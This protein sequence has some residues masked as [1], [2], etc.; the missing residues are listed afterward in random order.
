MAALDSGRANDNPGVRIW[1]RRIAW[2]E[3]FWIL[4]VGAVLLLPQR[5]AL[6]L[7]EPL[8]GA[9]RPLL[10]A[11][12]LIGWPVRVLA[13]GR[14]SA[15]AVTAVTRRSPLD[16]PIWLLVLCIPVSLW[17]SPDRAVSWAAA[18]YL[19]F[20]LA[21]YFAL[22]NWPPAIIRP[23]IVAWALMV[24]GLG[25]AVLAPLMSRPTAAQLSHLPLLGAVLGRLGPQRL[26][27]VNVNVLAGSVVLILPLYVAMAVRRGWSRLRW[28]LLFALG[29]LVML[30]VILITRSRGAY[31]AA[32]AAIAVVVVLR[33]PRLLYALP[34]I[35]LAGVIGVIAIGPTRVLETGSWILGTADGSLG[36]LSGRLEVWSRAIYALQD[37]GITGLGLG[38][39]SRVVPLMYPYLT[40]APDFRVDHAHNLFLQVG[41][42]L[43]IPGLIAYLALLI[44]TFALLASALRR[45]V[46]MQFWGPG[47]PVGESRGDPLL[48]SLAAGAAGGL[49]AMLVHGLF[50][51]TIWNS[52]PA[53]LPW[54]LIALSVLVGLRP[55]EPAPTTSP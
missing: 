41:L 14:R 31:V 16:W 22:L 8:T 25:I 37:F 32:A 21:L 52:R 39:F 2:L 3:P 19:V 34:V 54:V 36:G 27:E 10:I 51:V 20:G 28:S 45:E 49:T 12:L 1:L 47:Y 48:W 4:A 17:A 42:D 6:A 15:G 33:W 13:Y 23:E 18:G 50:D 53:F 43:G 35:L 55:T 30:L 44:D 9:W 38:T 5:F 40:L 46:P 24:L 11:L 7:P 26:E 29:A